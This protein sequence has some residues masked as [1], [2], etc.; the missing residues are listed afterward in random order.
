MPTLTDEQAPIVHYK[1]QRLVV[2]AYAGTGKTFTLAR[3]AE[4][5]PDSV[6]LY[7]A[8]NRAIRDDAQSRFPR[9][10]HCKTTH[11]LAFASKGKHY[12]H[13]LVGGL[14]LRDIATTLGLSDWRMVTGV[15]NAVNAFLASADDTITEIHCGLAPNAD[16]NAKD[17]VAL[18]V[19]YARKLWTLMC[20]KDSDAIGMTHD[21][22]FKLWQLSRPDLSKDYDIVL[23]DEAQD[24][25]PCAEA[26]VLNQPR[27]RIVL[28]GDPY[29]GIY[30]FRGARNAMTSSRLKDAEVMHLTKSFRFG[31]RVSEVANDLLALQGETKPLQGL[32]EG[33]CVVPAGQF[34]LR[35]SPNG[36]VTFL[37]RTMMGVLQTALFFSLRKL[38][39]YFVGGIDA[40]PMADFEDLHL[41]ATN[42]R[43]RVR[44]KRLL[45]EFDDYATYKAMAEDS[46]DPEMQR[47][48]KVLEAHP[49]LDKD[50]AVLRKYVVSTPEEAVIIVTTAHRAK[51]LEWECVY[52]VDDFPDIL[53]PEMEAA[54]RIAETNL[55][56]VAAT[57]AQRLLATNPLLQ[58]VQANQAYRRARLAKRNVAQPSAAG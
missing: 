44:N 50:L 42:Q 29:Q 30:Q 24:T 32:A 47:T 48:V 17:R 21:G 13:K 2:K 27:C 19:H 54:D 7:I 49:Q 45:A 41:L 58:K 52:L 18:T 20:D 4:A 3:F 10:V 36:Q 40:Y 23:L 46:G 8:Y 22:Y 14:R 15:Q 16:A 51:G 28:A 25:N 43:D 57:R 9:N 56:Y 5:N 37:A 53:D 35:H 55:F 39:V 12:K 33:D 11:Q 26:V 6:I 1:G 31:P 38:P 34:H